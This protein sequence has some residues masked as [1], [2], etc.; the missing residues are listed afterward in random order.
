[1]MVIN[2]FSSGLKIIFHIVRENCAIFA[3]I[4]TE[5]TV[6]FSFKCTGS[7][8][9][10]L[11]YFFEQK[12]IDPYELSPFFYKFDQQI[13]LTQYHRMYQSLNQTLLVARS[14]YLTKARSC[15]EKA[16]N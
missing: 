2:D 6:I 5:L 3:Q 1:M 9:Y 8:Y 15:R 12:K 4:M 10:L 14:K 7:E 13:N 11:Y 16:C